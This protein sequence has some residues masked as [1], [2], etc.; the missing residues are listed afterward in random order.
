MP[1][2]KKSLK[3]SQKVKKL[4]TRSKSN[5]SQKIIII[6]GGDT[7]LAL[8]NVLEKNNQIIIIEIDKS[9]A[10][11]IANRTNFLVI[12]E[13]GIDSNVL[14]EAGIDKADALIA[15]TGDDKT[16]LMACMIAKNTK[17]KKI[18]S[19]VNSPKN[20]SLFSH[21]DITKIIS[22]VQSAVALTRKA[23]YERS[24]ER[25]IH[26][27]N[28][29]A[30]IIELKVGK[31]S[32]YIGKKAQIKNAVVAAITRKDGSK[33]I[34][35]SEDKKIKEGDLLIIAARTKDVSKILEDFKG[36]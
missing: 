1:K 18:I 27:I 36:E 15:T 9:I 24:D 21:L 2:R 35:S 5:K 20:E 4:F 22:K 10:E 13:D 30:Q 26:L 29:E 32:R 11:E 6:G 8:A 28:G 31:K 19:I 17:L 33:I 12:N 23:L 14:K 3:I 16:N 25:I 34:I 7:G